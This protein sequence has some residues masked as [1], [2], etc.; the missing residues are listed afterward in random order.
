MCD[1]CCVL[2]V[3][4]CVLCVVCFVLVLPELKPCSVFDCNVLYILTEFIKKL[5]HALSFI[6]SLAQCFIV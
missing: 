5:L 3:V 1:V 4:C 2:C 6:R